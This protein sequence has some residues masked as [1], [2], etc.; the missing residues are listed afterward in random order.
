MILH[1]GQPEP[2][3]NQWPISP[4]ARSIP[5]TESLVYSPPVE[6]SA[7]SIP[8]SHETLQ[9]PVP[10]QEHSSLYQE[11]DS[12]LAVF[13]TPPPTPPQ[14]A[15]GPST[16]A[17]PRLQIPANPNGTFEFLTRL[18]KKHPKEF[19]S[20]ICLFGIDRHIDCRTIGYILAKLCE[21]MKKR[22]V[23]SREII[24]FLGSIE[25]C[26]D[27]YQCAY[28]LEFGSSEVLTI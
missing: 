25:Q 14:M 11:Q 23:S 21:R 16:I 12:T 1:A 8:N 9:A 5:S 20:L 24:L 19:E 4:E 28:A 10:C 26:Q 27:L 6:A 22:Y 15:T 3:A 13:L 18:L 17:C 2:F 7:Y